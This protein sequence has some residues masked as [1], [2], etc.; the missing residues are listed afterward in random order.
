[1]VDFAEQRKNMVESQVRPSDITDRRIMRAMLEVP[2][3]RFVPDAL[4]AV[5]YADEA[6]PLATG[7][8]ADAL[9]RAP[10]PRLLAKLIQLLEIDASDRVLVIGGGRGYAAALISRMAAK[11]IVLEV[12]EVLA[13]ASRSNLAAAGCQNTEV[14]VGPLPAGWPAESPYDGVLIDG[15]VEQVSEDL[16]DQLKDGGRMAAV[17]MLGAIGRGSVWRRIGATFDRRDS[18]DG[19]AAVLPGF[20]R[21]P[22]FVF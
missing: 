2:R 15:G 10:A 12:S 18:F 9:R 21:A 7:R 16:L 8:S 4:A 5:A 17:L 20:E 14:V 13:S 19:I 3:E 1:M 22:E 6:V 11:V